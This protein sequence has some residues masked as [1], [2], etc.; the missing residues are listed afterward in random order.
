MNNRELSNLIGNT[1]YCTDKI[2]HFKGNL[3]H[4]PEG[5]FVPETVDMASL[6]S[7]IIKHYESK[8]YIL[9][10]SVN[11]RDGILMFQGGDHNEKLITI[12]IQAIKRHPTS[13][14]VAYPKKEEPDI[15]VGLR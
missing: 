15:R 4:I 14:V 5:F 9:P 7:A 1:F 6:K 13:V 3:P 10:K 2:R 8:G 12:T 11:A